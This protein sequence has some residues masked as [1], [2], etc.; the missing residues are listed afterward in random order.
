MVERQVP[1][2]NGGR[3]GGHGLVHRGHGS[4][5]ACGPL[6]VR[7]PSQLRPCATGGDARR[8]ARITDANDDTYWISGAAQ[9]T[10]D[11]LEIDLGRVAD[12]CSV[13]VSVGSHAGSYPR[14]LS[15]STSQDAVTWHDI[16]LRED[17]RARLSVRPWINRERPRWSCHSGISRRGSFACASKPTSRRR[18][19]SSTEMAVTTR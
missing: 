7:G 14:S 8:S 9:Q 2:T 3:N 17:W 4:R 19:G 1:R 6:R 13:R 5:S 11:F 16:F 18:R 10:G 15:V 12:A